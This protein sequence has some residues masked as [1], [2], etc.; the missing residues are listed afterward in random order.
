MPQI[1]DKDLAF[2]NKRFAKTK[3]SEDDV[4][5]F[6]ATIA[7]SDKTTSHKTRLDKRTLDAFVNSLSTSGVAMGINHANALPVGRVYDGNMSGN[8]LNAKFY[9]LKDMNVTINEN[10][11]FGAGTSTY[12]TNDIEKMINAGTLFD[13]SV[14]F[15]ADR[16]KY[17]CSVCKKPIMSPDCP[18]MPGEVYEG[19][20]CIAIISDEN[21]ILYEVSVCMAGALPG[22]EI[23]SLSFDSKEDWLAK[24]FTNSTDIAHVTFSMENDE[25]KEEVNMA[26]KDDA[27]MER[28]SN[29]AVELKVKIEELTAANE[30]LKEKNLLLSETNE[31]L[32][33]DCGDLEIL[34][35]GLKAKMAELEANAKIGQHYA[36]ALELEILRLG[37]ATEGNEFDKDL[38]KKQL[39]ALSIEEREKIKDTLTQRL[40]SVVKIGNADTGDVHK[41]EARKTADDSYLYKIR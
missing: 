14:G 19:K 3:L 20:E 5:G 26:K 18:H 37:V 10:V 38:M 21:A 32:A 35:V 13:V 1:S 24:T 40:A 36:T 11:G 4:F 8:A 39:S 6:N 33:N 25:G 9:V 17:G 41:T 16:N 2:I 7:R 22:A 28:L 27:E 15:Q 34:N 12:N 29:E 23:H 31:E 30:E